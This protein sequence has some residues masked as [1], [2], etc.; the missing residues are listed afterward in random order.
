MEKYIVNLSGG[1]EG[2]FYEYNVVIEANCKD[3]I[4][5]AL[6]SRLEKGCGL[7]GHMFEHYNI[8][9][10]NEWINNNTVSISDL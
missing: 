3:D 6:L 10:L 8:Y 5:Y 2:D 7:R 4:D 9:T 1:G